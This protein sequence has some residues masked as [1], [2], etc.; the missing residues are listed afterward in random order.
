MQFCRAHKA[1]SSLLTPNGKRNINVLGRCIEFSS[2]GRPS[3]PLLCPRSG[4]GQGK[5]PVF[6]SGGTLTS[7]IAASLLIGLCDQKVICFELQRKVGVGIDGN[8]DLWWGVTLM[9]PPVPGHVEDVEEQRSHDV[10]SSL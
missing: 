6:P 7:R 8:R 1:E 4:R 5:G 10:L 9:G 2:S 3:T